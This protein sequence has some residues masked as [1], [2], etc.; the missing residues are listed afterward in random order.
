MGRCP[1][2]GAD[3][4]GDHHESCRGPPDSD[5]RTDG[6]TDDT[7]GDGD[8]LSRRAMLGYTAGSAAAT[9]GA[10]GAGWLAFVYERTGPEEDVVR[11]Y[12]TALSRQKFNT[13]TLLYHEDAPG[14]PP[15]PA[16][17]PGLQDTDITV[18]EAE[19]T[20]R[21]EDIGL[22]SVAEL[23]F[24]DV[25]LVFDS[26]WETKEV[27]TGFVVARRPD[28]EWRLWRDPSDLE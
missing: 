21:N 27:E 14:T 25:T 28:D 15:S 3:I 1:T 10:I 7:A 16:E 5:A 11:E 12:V 22:E 18:E 9:L 24:V 20:A 19:V 17:N 4:D 23:A 26:A 2:C 13:A 8:G 6:G